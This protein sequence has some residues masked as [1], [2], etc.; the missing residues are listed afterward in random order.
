MGSRLPSLAR[1]GAATRTRELFGNNG[2]LCLNFCLLRCRRG[3]TL[4]RCCA[5]SSVEE[6]FLHTEGVA[7]SS[8]AARTIGSEVV[9]EPLPRR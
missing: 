3:D 6:H 2:L 4:G 7:G 8:P 1:H 9:I 5:L